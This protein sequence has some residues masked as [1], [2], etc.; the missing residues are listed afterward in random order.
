[1]YYFFTR[2]CQKLYVQ[3]GLAITQ[4]LLFFERGFFNDIDLIWTTQKGEVLVEIK[5][6]R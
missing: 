2:S 3:N 6:N 5:G 4:P 1:M